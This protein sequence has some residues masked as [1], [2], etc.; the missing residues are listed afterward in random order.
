MFQSDVNYSSL[1][2]LAD[3][4]EIV[5]DKLNS[6]NRYIV[7]RIV[8]TLR[9]WISNGDYKPGQRLPSINELAVNNQIEGSHKTIADAVSVLKE[10]GLVETFERIGTFVYDKKKPIIVDYRKMANVLKERIDSG[11]YKF[12]LPTYRE[13]ETEFKRSRGTIKSA[14][15]EIEKEYT[16]YREFKRAYIGVN[17]KRNFM[18]AQFKQFYPDRVPSR[19]ELIKDYEALY[20]QISRYQKRTGDNLLDRLVPASQENIDV[21]HKLRNYIQANK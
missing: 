1:E 15:K 13:L 4:P 21:G 12:A 17:G 19:S 11:E 16:I 10:D 6:Q 7:D 14:I 3:N 9:D 2:E 18:E 20:R 8:Q 5:S